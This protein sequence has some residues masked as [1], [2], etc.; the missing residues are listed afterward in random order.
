M[1]KAQMVT[2]QHPRFV[3]HQRVALTAGNRNE[4]RQLWMTDISKGGLFVETDD[5]PPLRTQ[6]VVHLETPDGAAQ[7]SAEVVHVLDPETAR[8]MNTAAGVGLQFVDLD[9]R[10][11]KAIEDYVE[12]LVEAL[13]PTHDLS[14]PLADEAAVIAVMKQVLRGFEQEDLYAALGL[15]PLASD[16]EVQNKITELVKILSVAAPGLTAAQA[17]RAT[18]AR[19]LV[20]RSGAM[21]ADPERRLDYDL[22]HGHIFARE[23][24]ATSTPA[25]QERLRKIWH[26][27]NSEALAQA[28][29]HASLALR[30]EGVMKYREAIE[31]A[32]QALQ[33]D[34]FNSELWSAVDTWEA[35]L[36][37]EQQ[38]VGDPVEE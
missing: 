28:Q 37:L 24:L 9:D 7:L 22:R 16:R 8:A 2:R 18:H 35:R 6:V 4:L 5:P 33:Y 13:V 21:F 14:Q 17:S 1:L 30:Y 31:A 15:D 34:P 11:R 36:R 25:E 38:T 20:R 12:G 26:R 19:N 32:T 29:K 3:A 10:H 23:R 27:N